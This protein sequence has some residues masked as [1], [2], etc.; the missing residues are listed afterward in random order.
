M[1]RIA[2]E[3]GGS[4]RAGSYINDATKLEWECK[5]RHRWY[6]TPNNIKRGRWCPKC[7]YEASLAKP[8]TDRIPELRKLARKYGGDCLSRT[9]LKT[10]VKLKWRCAKGHQWEALLGNVEKGQWCPVCAR[11][12]QW[13]TLEDMHRLARKRGGTCISK[14][15]Y[16]SKVK[17]KWC[18]KEG[19]VWEAIPSQVAFGTWCPACLNRQP[20]YHP[21]GKIEEMKAIAKE[22]GGECLSTEYGTARIALTWRCSEGHEWKSTPDLIKS[23]AWCAD[24]Y[25]SQRSSLVEMVAIAKWKGGRCLSKT[26]INDETKL[27]WECGRR[28]RWYAKPNLIKAGSW[29]PQCAIVRK[30]GIKKPFYDISH[31]QIAAEEKG[32]RC[33]SK[34][35]KGMHKPLTW[36]CGFGHR[37]GTP[38]QVV[39]RGG[40]CPKCDRLR[41]IRRITDV[42]RGEILTNDEIKIATG[43]ARRKPAPWKDRA[44][45]R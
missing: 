12:K 17:L 15:Y 44:S 35:Y 42:H 20:G 24:C 9:Y 14:K 27:Q 11:Q 5:K 26:Y 2:K 13:H 4:C 3:R 29:C 31:M 1:Q 40:W 19:H 45:N 23:G 36:E 33:V 22:R 7:A 18:C 43:R 41:R 39:W 37:W 21:R 16:G 10:S 25:G 32:G 30:R 8:K 34:I 38:A 28:H 6:A